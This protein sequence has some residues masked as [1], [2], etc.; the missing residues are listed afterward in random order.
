MYHAWSLYYPGGRPRR[1][2]G[3][4]LR[5]GSFLAVLFGLVIAA[6]V[7]T[8][9]LAASAPPRV[10]APRGPT[11]IGVKKPKP[12]PADD[13]DAGAAD[14]GAAAAAE[15]DASAAAANAAAAAAS[16]DAGPEPEIFVPVPPPTKDAAEEDPSAG[17]EKKRSSIAPDLASIA[18]TWYLLPT[19]S[20]AYQK[21]A[22]PIDRFVYGIISTRFGLIVTAAPYPK[23]TV[24]GHVGF[25]ASYVR[26]GVGAATVI[27]N[28]PITT[29]VIL[30]EATV[31]YHPTEWLDFKLGHQRLPFSIA[32]AVVLTGQMFPQRPGPTST[33][34]AGPDDGALATVTF[35][36]ERLRASTGVFNGQSLALELPGSTAVG[37]TWSAFLAA[38]P[39]GSMNPQEGDPKRGPFRFELGV[40]G[41]LR[42]GELYDASGFGSTAFRDVRANAAIRASFAGAFLQG[43]YLYRLQTDDLSLRPA[44]ARGLYVEGSYYIPVSTV[45]LSPLAR[46]GYSI[47]NQEFDPRSANTFE[48][49]IAFYPLADLEQPDS[50]RIITHYS[51]ELR[52]PFREASHGAVLNLQMVW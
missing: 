14:A 18:M 1:E 24:T 37:P 22:V 2:A 47:V 42:K 26:A 19:G 13:A 5:R 36:E 20:V 32:H 7:L 52:R 40:G 49:G 35:L 41:L 34:L 39:L 25:D 15:P 16:A 11:G 21:Q 43:E 3:D 23:W 46:Y 44:S 31:A 38:Q 27:P 51:Y 29:T 6:V 10:R 33:F 48:G 50:L 8:A 12:P 30:D 28:G 4:V 45:A 9:A 17:G